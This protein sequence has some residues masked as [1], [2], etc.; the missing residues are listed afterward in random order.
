MLIAQNYA[1]RS[2]ATLD[3]AGL[4]LNLSTEQSR[5]PVRLHASIQD[6]LAYARLMKTLYAVVTSNLLAPKRDRSAYFEWVQQRYLEEV[7]T[8]QA[9]RL[10][11]V[12]AWLAERK[13]L[14]ERIAA[15]NKRINTLTV[16]AQ[17]GDFYQAQRKYWNWLRT[18]DMDMWW[19]L[20]PVVSVHPDCLIF[21]A[22]S[23]D[24]SSYGRV[25]VPMDRL[26]IHDAVDYG[27]TN[28]DFSPALNREIGRIRSYRET[29]LHVG[30]LAVGLET[31]AGS[32]V[33]KKIDL[34]PTWVRGFLQVQ[35]AA[36]LPGVEARFSASTVADVLSVIRRRHE[37]RGPRS[38]RFVLAP[39]EHPQIVVE[40]WGV[41]V[42]ERVHTF[43]GANRQEIRVW[44][45]RRLLVLEG[46]LPFAT[47]VRVRLMG[48]GLPSY[49]SVL[50]ETS[51]FDM[52]LS[53]WTQNDWSRAAQFDLLASISRPS[54][55]DL[56]AVSRVL[57]DRL[58]GTP[59]EFAAAS[60]LSRAQTTAALQ[61]LTRE[62]RA[63]YDYVTGTY[64][65]RQLFPFMPE[66][67]A[68]DED[69]RLAA[70]RRLIE[71]KAVTWTDLPK[72]T[73]ATPAGSPPAPTAAPAATATGGA[74]VAATAS[75]TPPG[76]AQWRTFSYKD[77]KS[78]KFWNV[79]LS[80]RSHVVHFGR[81]GTDGQRQQK[82][83]ATAQQAQVS[84]DKLVKEKT[85]KG[86]VE[87]TPAPVPSAPV[88]PTQTAAAVAPAA[89]GEVAPA[90]ERTRFEATVKGEKAFEVVLDVDAD[91]RVVYAQCTCSAYRR[92][93]MR[94]GPCPH[95]LAVSVAAARY[96][97]EN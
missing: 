24:E 83:F 80:G 41:V 50:A 47:E 45:R 89:S 5:P 29:G 59:E 19:V 85:G 2:S 46:L 26:D 95:I 6:G 62:G 73:M 57:Q 14:N 3:A 96:A 16:S 48:T 84:Y 27:T 49:W 43:E 70:A 4:G 55:A 66:P 21:E 52:G 25:T 15:L 31:A 60:G 82:E 64:R 93:K 11:Q 51:R 69:P 90:M 75:V 71:R 68:M 30:P 32:V 23:Q 88:T 37:D 17:G 53:G 63:M 87:T 44:G 81:T 8:E 56:Q 86:Y 9:H 74:A 54:D 36:T 22:F 34:P 13:D 20:D 91:G 40:P 39:G 42:P 61:A 78:D 1:Q 10:T 79:L 97:A 92:D 12:P 35:S 94:K 76:T 72:R 58:F 38:L 28:I 7:T 67:A 65:W 18:Y 33:E 77:P